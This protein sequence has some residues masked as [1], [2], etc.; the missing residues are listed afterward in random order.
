MFS[1]RAR[2]ENTMQK[3]KATVAVIGA[4]DYIG[5][6]IAKKVL[7]RVDHLH[8]AAPG[9]LHSPGLEPGPFLRMQNETNAPSTL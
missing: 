7:G 8:A 4:S 5:G 1:T 2:P 6:E 9:D 3:I